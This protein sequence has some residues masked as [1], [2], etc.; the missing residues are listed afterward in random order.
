[1]TNNVTRST[2][3]YEILAWSF[4]VFGLTLLGS[5]CFVPIREK[6]FDDFV[7]LSVSQVDLGEIPF[8]EQG[9]SEF[10][11]TNRTQQKIPFKATADCSC[12]VLEP[13]SGMLEPMA[14]LRIRVTYK[15]KAIGTNNTSFHHEGSDITVSLLANDR[16]LDQFLGV[17]GQSVIPAMID[18]LGLRS[19][20]EP[21]KRSATSFVFSIAE[22]VESVTLKS[23][24]DFLAGLVLSR[25][26]SQVELKA[27]V[28]Q[29][30][31]V[32][33]GDAEIEFVVK[34]IKKPMLAHLPVSITV[35]K[36]YQI[37]SKTI[38]LTPD[39]DGT[40]KISPKH[41]VSKVEFVKFDPDSSLVPARIAPDGLS[42][43]VWCS[44]LRSESF[45]IVGK[46]HATI[47]VT[48]SS[49]AEL[50]FDE[51]VTFVVSEGGLFDC[52]T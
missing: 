5:F 27:E 50:L 25:S 40:I 29:L 26:G 35:E 39:S 31:G 3:R 51:F 22:D 32:H 18:P 33:I 1:M 43:L 23:T 13:E 19:A 41:G 10:F 44:D 17:R 37:E 21:F 12:T 11:M 46:I 7:R 49:G 15:P 8:G 52:G 28:E 2:A 42:V 48:Q 16:R 14:S 4:G 34:G 45:P 6:H 47:R 30:P 24:P 20:I 38:V 36:P 9:K